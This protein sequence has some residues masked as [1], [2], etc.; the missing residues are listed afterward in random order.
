MGSSPNHRDM[1]A[2]FHRGF[3]SALSKRR[4]SLEKPA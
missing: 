4:K 3:N 1:F 2:D